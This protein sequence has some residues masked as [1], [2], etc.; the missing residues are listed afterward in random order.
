MTP[1]PPKVPVPSRPRPMAP[2]PPP[3]TAPMSRPGPLAITLRGG[4]V[5]RSWDD[6]LAVSAQR[7][8]D[9]RDELIS[10]RLGAALARAGYGEFIPE[11]DTPGSPD[12]RLDDWLARVPTTKP[13]QPE[14]DVQPGRI[15]APADAERVER[16][17]RLNNV[18]YR[19]L[20]VT[21]R[22]EPADAT[23][24][25]IPDEYRERPLVTVEGLNLPVTILVPPGRPRARTATIVVESNGGDRRVPVALTTAASGTAPDGSETNNRVALPIR[26]ALG[27]A[28]GVA[29][30][31]GMLGLGLVGRAT[32]W[33]ATAAP[34]PDLRASIVVLALVGSAVG[35]WAVG[36]NA[37]PRDRLA[38]GFS[39]AVAGVFAADLVTALSR[40]LEPLLSGAWPVAFFIWGVLGAVLATLVRPPAP[41]VTR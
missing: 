2:P 23:W 33:I 20:R 38:G 9:L 17:L 13:G 10:G 11:A 4:T 1:D 39:G 8:N 21:V 22:V 40:S 32:G 28:A 16:R 5:C 29:C 41:E 36:R 18:G 35:A 19:L 15:E 12:E 14:L 24:L 37:V 31:L 6:F 34:G 25:V 3:G 27:A 7:W 30:R 26:L